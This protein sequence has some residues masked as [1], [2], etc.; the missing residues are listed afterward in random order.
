LNNY[1][2]STHIAKL[3]QMKNLLLSIAAL[4]CIIFNAQAQHQLDDLLKNGS[5][6]DS[7]K[8]ITDSAYKVYLHNKFNS[9]SGTQVKGG[10]VLGTS[11]TID[12][13]SV[14]VNLSVKPIAHVF[15]LQPSIAATSKNGF[16]AIFDNNAYSKTLTGGLNLQ[17]F[18]SK[19]FSNYDKTNAIVLHN[20]LRLLRLQYVLNDKQAN[21]AY[22]KNTI[23]TIINILNKATKDTK[24][25]E[26]IRLDDSK[27]IVLDDDTSSN[28]IVAK[29]YNDYKKLTDTLI[30]IKIVT[31]GFHTQDINEQL[32]F[33]TKLCKKPDKAID[34]IAY[35]NYVRKSDSLQLNASF[36]STTTPWFSGG[37][38]YNHEIYDIADATSAKLVR[39]V[40]NEYIT[41]NIAY[42]YLKSYANGKRGYLS[43]TLYY[44][45][46]HDFNSNNAITAEQVSNYSIGT[47]NL[48]QINKTYTFY[49][50]MPNRINNTYGEADYIYFNNNINIGFEAAVKGG[51][52]DVDGDNLGVRLGMFVPVGEKDK[53]PILIEPLVRFMGLSGNLND[54]W[55]DHFVFGFNVSIKFADFLF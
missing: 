9:I 40:A 13:K 36:I 55:K 50:N 14:T 27:S 18:L 53:Q 49:A 46:S 20:R 31:A 21:E 47:A 19:N 42:N 35:N 32:K 15:Y 51:V 37:L 16:A 6:A 45:N 52:N 48:N 11:A 5:K 8:L 10:K 54:F 28:I 26:L 22:F 4:V 41:A 38:N 43:V 3:Y 39:T 34:E 17:L 29:D 1:A 33:Y 2:N 23:D 30:K 24:L 7:G 44:K 12:D 25:S